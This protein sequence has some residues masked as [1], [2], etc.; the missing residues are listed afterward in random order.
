[1]TLFCGDGAQPQPR[2]PAVIP[3]INEMTCGYGCM[4]VPDDGL[5][6]GSLWLAV[7]C[8]AARAGSGLG[9]SDCKFPVVL[10]YIQ[11]LISACWWKRLIKAGHWDGSRWTDRGG[12]DSAAVEAGYLV[13]WIK[14]HLMT[15]LFGSIR[16]KR[17][18]ILRIQEIFCNQNIK[19]GKRKKKMSQMSMRI[20][21]W[22][23][24]THLFDLLQYQ[25]F[26]CWI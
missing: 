18:S 13:A 9:G 8:P 14:P 21:F 20:I 23:L 3:R 19:K 7:K 17:A 15:H 22:C 4:D 6:A 16:G 11:D 1:M 2:D 12:S 10:F 26:K 5:S 25:H 24:N